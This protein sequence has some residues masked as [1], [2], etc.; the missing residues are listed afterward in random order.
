MILGMS[1]YA[2]TVLHVVVS[3]I[4]IVAGFILLFGMFS[5]NRLPGWT[6][7]FLAATAL[8][9]VTGF[10]FPIKGFTPALAFG[11]IS[12]ML[13][14]ATLLALYAYNLSG[15]WRWIYVGC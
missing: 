3:L 2:F 8:T 11:I 6:A 12:T 13:L 7:F 1:T 14:A 9:V 10:L 4:A 5:S 15:P